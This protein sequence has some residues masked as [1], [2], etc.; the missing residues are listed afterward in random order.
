[1]YYNTY[2]FH[3]Y[4]FISISI[5]FF[6]YWPIS[7]FFL[8]TPKLSTVSDNKT[9]PLLFLI[10]T[11]FFHFNLKNRLFFYFYIKK[12]DGKIKPEQSS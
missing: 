5:Y 11:N 12:E 2:F 4:L 8:P 1:M 9:V 6:L 7:I 3:L 10:Q